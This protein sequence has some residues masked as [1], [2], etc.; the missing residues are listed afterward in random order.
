MS[1]EALKYLVLECSTWFLFLGGGHI[2]E[3]YKVMRT[4]L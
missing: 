4:E 2:L 1:L 3:D